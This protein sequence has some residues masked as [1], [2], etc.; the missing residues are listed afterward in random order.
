M[1]SVL[2]R[3]SVVA[4][5]AVLVIA[6][7]LTGMAIGTNA[8]TF[9]PG[10]QNDYR[11]PTDIP[12]PEDDPYTPA[13]AE[14]GAALF[15]DPVLSESRTMSCATCHQ[16]GLGWSDGRPR[17]IGDRQVAMSLHAPTLLDDAWIPILGWDG[18]Y[19]DIE[20]VTFRAISGDANMNLPTKEALDRL[21]ASPAYARRFEAAFG[22]GPITAERVEDAL[23]TYERGIRSGTSPFDRWVDGDEH[24]VTDAAKRGFAVFEG[25]AHCASCHSGWAFTDYSFE[26]IGIGTGT[27]IGRAAFFP[28]SVALRY[29]FKTPTLRD[30]ALRAPYMHDGSLPTLEAVVDHYDSGGIDRPSR[31]PKI[32]PLHLNADEKSDLIAFLK[33]LTGDNQSKVFALQPR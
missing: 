14:L 13:K 16:P 4:V 24:A 2:V 28:S 15:F 33:S 32:Q 6:P 20:S 18:K 12:Y 19:P 3:K 27:D 21:S 5:I 1:E 7:L 9:R 22:P 25:K 31:S 30:V 11:R 23:A 10:W 8:P 17:A 26:D 29:A